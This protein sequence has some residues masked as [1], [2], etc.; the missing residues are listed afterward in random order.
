M[1][2]SCRRLSRSWR[3]KRI[4]SATMLRMLALIA[5]S[6]GAGNTPAAFASDSTHSAI[7][8]IAICSIVGRSFAGVQS[9]SVILGSGLLPSARAAPIAQSYRR[10]AARAPTWSTGLI[11][12]SRPI[13]DLHSSAAAGSDSSAMTAAMSGRR[14]VISQWSYRDDGSRPRRDQVDR[15]RQRWDREDSRRRE[16]ERMYREHDEWQERQR[17]RPTSP[18]W[19]HDDDPRPPAQAIYGAVGAGEIDADATLERWRRI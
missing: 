1:I 13:S 17:F 12:R 18:G 11:S 9:A 14:M 6:S 2:H 16:D 7:A 8:E 3:R 15:D 19:Y 5:A 4:S 10:Y